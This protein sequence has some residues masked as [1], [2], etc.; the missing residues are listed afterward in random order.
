MEKLFYSGNL[1]KLQ[2]FCR[3]PFLGYVFIFSRLHHFVVYG[4]HLSH[5]ISY[6]FVIISVFKCHLHASFVDLWRLVTFQLNMMFMMV[7]LLLS[8]RVMPHDIHKFSSWLDVQVFFTCIWI[9]RRKSVTMHAQSS[10]SITL[11]TFPWKKILETRER[12][13]KTFLTQNG[14]V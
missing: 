5:S 10:S 12:E 2:F 1:R 4:A 3:K 6:A 14:R 7:F 9:P 11:L 13:E 8:Y